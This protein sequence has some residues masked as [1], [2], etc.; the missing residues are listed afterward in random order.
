MREILLLRFDAPLISFGA[1][2]VDAKGVVQL[3]PALSMLTGLLANALG[4]ERVAFDALDRLQ[5]RVRYAARTD[6][7]GEPLEDYQIVDLG[8]PWMLPE[9]AGWT[10]RGRIAT[11]GGASSEGLHIRERHYRADSVHT[12]ALALDPADESPTLDD[13]ERALRHPARPLFLGRKTCLPAAEVVLGRV[14]AVT[15]LEALRAAPRIEAG[16]GD[17]GPL[18]AWW[19]PGEGDALA[20]RHAMPIPVTDERDWRNQIV[21]GRRTMLHA[22]VDPPHG[23]AR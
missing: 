5:E 2:M 17:E 22:P 4:Y 15:C 19:C 10:T 12:V 7:A 21:T 6:R 11:R 20:E 16:R 18:P 3:F 1:P 8:A 14:N 13:L 9:Q 23:G